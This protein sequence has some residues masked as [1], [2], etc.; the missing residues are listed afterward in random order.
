MSRYKVLEQPYAKDGFFMDYEDTETGE[1]CGQGTWMVGDL[2]TAMTD[3]VIRLGRIWPELERRLKEGNYCGNDWAAVDCLGKAYNEIGKLCDFYRKECH[4]KLVEEY[5]KGKLPNHCIVC[6]G[7]GK[8]TPADTR[9][10]FYCRLGFG[11]Y[12]DCE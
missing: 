4:E 7:D 6:E 12:K 9:P 8:V 5:L 10:C 1:H 3:V 11:E 2:V